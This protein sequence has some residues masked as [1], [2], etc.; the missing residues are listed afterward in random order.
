MPDSKELVAE[1]NFYFDSSTCG[2]GFHGDDERKKVVGLRL[3]TGGRPPLHYQ[4][5]KDK[6]PIGHR[7]VIQLDDGD[8]YVMSEKASGNDEKKTNIPTLKHATG[9]AKFTKL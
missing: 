7:A 4:W 1:G 9:A 3:S 6:K 5:F 8:V 2:V